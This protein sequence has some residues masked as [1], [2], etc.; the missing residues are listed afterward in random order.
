MLG[1]VWAQLA[2]SDSFSLD[3]LIER[4]PG[5]LDPSPGSTS[6]STILHESDVL[7]RGNDIAERRL[8]RM[9]IKLG[10]LNSLQKL[11]GDTVGLPKPVVCGRFLAEGGIERY[12]SA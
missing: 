7:S 4:R 11:I 3:S 2:A 9:S 5:T 12:T 6:A 10:L 8:A 1:T